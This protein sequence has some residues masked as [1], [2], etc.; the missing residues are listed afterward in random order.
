MKYEAHLKRLR[1]AARIG[2]VDIDSGRFKSFDE[3]EEL[4][5]HLRELAQAAIG[6]HSLESSEER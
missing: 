1:E 4:C 2:I 3:P 5:R 6:G